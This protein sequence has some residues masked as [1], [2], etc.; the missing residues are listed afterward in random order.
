MKTIEE[1]RKV[2]RETVFNKSASPKRDIM[3][4]ERKW[5]EVKKET[6]ELLNKLSNICSDTK[7]DDK[8][9]MAL[10]KSLEYNLKMW[11]KGLK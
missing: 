10:I 4:P 1:L 11:K 8:S 6:G 7:S 5:N 2:V 9:T 3:T